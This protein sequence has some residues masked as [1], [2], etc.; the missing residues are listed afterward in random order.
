MFRLQ[1]IA[2]AHLTGPVVEALRADPSTADLTVI[3]GAGRDPEGDLI[4]C[5]VAE[6]D[7]SLLIDQLR[8]LGIGREGSL[9]ITTLEAIVSQE[10]LD[11]ARATP[12]SP[13]DAV[14]WEAVEGRAAQQAEPSWTLYLLEIIA[15][16]IAAMGLLLD[17]IVLIVGAM[18]VGPEYGPLSAVSLGI[19]RRKRHLVH[20]GIRSVLVAFPIAIVV[21]TVL[22]V[23]ALRTGLAPGA[24]E[25]GFLTTFVS[26]P[27]A[28]SVWLGVLVS[29]TTVPAAASIALSVAYWDFSE[30]VGSSIQLVVNVGCIVGAGIIVLAIERAE[31]VQQRRRRRRQARRAPPPG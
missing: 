17:S 9:S 10:A 18:I 1:V 31:F 15:V 14:L 11:A 23:L 6:E 13:Q 26:R 2:P 24:Y 5:D 29:I 3:T 20:D 8:E 21:T 4:Q 12:G 19:V 16:A 30:L 27:S 22:S 25:P 7:A 28:S